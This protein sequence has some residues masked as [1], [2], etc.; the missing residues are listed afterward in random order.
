MVGVLLVLFFLALLGCGL[1]AVRC[2]THRPA[3][4]VEPDPAESEDEEGQLMA[5]RVL[6]RRGFWEL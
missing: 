1:L 3:E 6:Y 5:K 2:R 4:G